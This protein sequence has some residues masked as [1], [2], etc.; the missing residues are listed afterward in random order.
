MWLSILTSSATVEQCLT[1]LC[2]S[3]LMVQQVCSSHG[4]TQLPAF[5]DSE[6]FLG[7]NGCGD[8]NN[9]CISILLDLYII[10]T[11]DTLLM[12][13]YQFQRRIIR[14]REKQTNWIDGWY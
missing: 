2:N 9:T 1:V 7:E 14:V 3:S 12:L 5:L 4:P 11:Y 8:G 13:L 10:E 6:V